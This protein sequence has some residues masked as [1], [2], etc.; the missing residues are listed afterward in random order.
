MTERT[1]VQSDARIAKSDARSIRGSRAHADDVRT[2]DQGTAFTE[3]DLEHMLRN[4]F[5]QEALPSIPAKPGWHRCWLSTT[6][7]YDPIHKRLRLGYQPVSMEQ[8]AGS[9]LENYRMTSGEF[10]G[11]VSCNEMVLFEIP[12][13]RYELIMRTYHHKMPMEEEQGIRA[14]TER[15]DT[16]RRGKKLMSFDDE[17]EGFRELGAEQRNAVPSFE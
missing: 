6:S 15:Q 17:D 12:Q 3:D 7:P 9:G 4:E 14:K 5:V 11:A 2:N 16:D 13:E 1:S 10:A 8:I